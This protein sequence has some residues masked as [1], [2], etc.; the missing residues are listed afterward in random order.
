MNEQVTALSVIDSIDTNIVQRTMDKIHAFQQIIQQAV[1]PGH[2]IG[3]IPGTEKPSLLKPGAEKIVMMMGL[4]SCYEIMDKVE[5][6]EKGFF[7]YN[8]RCTLSRN[9]YDI[10][11][12]VGNCNSRESKYVKADPYSVA[13]TILKMAK[14]RAYVDA[15]LSVASLSDIFTQDIED[16]DSLR[17][18]PN[19]PSHRD[20]QGKALKE[21]V[22]TFGKHKGRTLG[23]LL[24]NERGYC[25]WMSNSNNE[26]W[27]PVFKKLLEEEKAQTPADGTGGQD[28][29]A[30]N[31]PEPDIPPA[32]LKMA[33]K[34]GMTTQD[35][36]DFIQ[37]QFEKPWAELAGD[38]KSKVTLHLHELS[39]AGA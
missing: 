3:I 18:K 32:V 14:K 17:I 28:N 6:Y 2:D 11:E 12:G 23:D 24:Q 1:V 36:L 21:Q 16:M 4:S 10:C 35:L 39:Q 20:N 9:G 22:I 13:N 7:S 38:E 26:K 19:G 37:A 33:D 30:Q 25:E 8:I 29:T 31:E 5:D 15:A 27:S 34:A